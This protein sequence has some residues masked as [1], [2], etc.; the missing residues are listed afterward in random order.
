MTPRIAVGGLMFEENEK[1]SFSL[2]EGVIVGM[3][4]KDNGVLRIRHF[5]RNALSFPIDHD[6]CMEA[7]RRLLGVLPSQVSER[8]IFQTPTGPYGAGTFAGKN[9]V[10]RIWYCNRAPGLIIGAYSCPK[11]FVGD[12]LYHLVCKEAAHLVATAVFDRPSWGGDDPLTRVLMD[13]LERAERDRSSA[14]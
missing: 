13:D 7:A 1:W 11:E 14:K 10:Q 3:R 8:E 6:N 4:V 2:H 5:E 9:D 12:A